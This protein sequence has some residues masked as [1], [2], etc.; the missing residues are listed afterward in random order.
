MIFARKRDWIPQI[1]V[2]EVYFLG[3]EVEP[4]RNGGLFLCAEHGASLGGASPLWSH[5]KGNHKSKARVSI[6]R[7]NLKEAS[8][9]ALLRRTEIR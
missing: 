9:E 6:V 1:F 8:D 7:W 4:A 2:V 3:L 5:S